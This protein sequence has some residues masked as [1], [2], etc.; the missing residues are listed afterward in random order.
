MTGNHCL[1]IAEPDSREGELARLLATRMRAATARLEG[2][3]SAPDIP[4]VFLDAPSAALDRILRAGRV[5]LCVP[6][7][8][9]AEAMATLAPLAKS[10]VPPVLVAHT[11]LHHLFARER[12]RWPA[13]RLELIPP[14]VD[15]AAFKPPSGERDSDIVAVAKFPGWDAALGGELS[16]GRAAKVAVAPADPPSKLR[17]ALRR[18]GAVV[19]APR[20]RETGQ[21]AAELLAAMAC[22]AP[23]AAA[24]SF[25]I[26]HLLV[27][28]AEGLFFEVGDAGGAM[29]A[30]RRLLSDPEL[31]A[32]MGAAAAAKAA[33]FLGI[34]HYAERLARI[35]AA[36]PDAAGPQYHLIA[37]HGAVAAERRIP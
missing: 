15:L 9:P 34:D 4:A 29:D 1:L 18:A 3:A 6:A 37:A 26:E 30:V 23:I 25:G 19:V 28:E 24:R 22:G 35:A 8:S 12:L 2:A 5:V 7:D 33:R 21:G 31:A 17:K 16:R 27:D 36:P 32:R 20:V 10:E 13:A 11:P 14:A